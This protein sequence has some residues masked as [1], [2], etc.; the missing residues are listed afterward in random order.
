MI[1]ERMFQIGSSSFISVVPAMMSGYT[2][3]PLNPYAS[4]ITYATSLTILMIAPVGIFIF[5]AS[6]GWS[7]RLTGLW[8]STSLTLGLSGVAGMIMTGLAGISPS[9]GNYLLLLLQWIEFLVQPFCFVAAVIVILATEKFRRSIRYIIT[10]EGVWIRGGLLS[11]QEHMVPY[12]QIG[13]IVFEQDFLG[14]MFNY[15]TLIP[16]SMTRWGQEISFRGIGATGQKDNFG[17]GIGYA[18]GREEGSRYPLDCLY[19]I[20]DPKKAQ[21][22]LTELI[23]RHD[24]REDE[25]VSY[26]KKIYETDVAKTTPRGSGIREPESTVVPGRS[27]PDDAGNEPFAGTAAAGKMPEYPEGKVIRVHDDVIP[28]TTMSPA[29]GNVR[30]IPPLAKTETHPSLGIPP[31]ESVLDQIKKLG[32]LK[33][34]GIITEEEFTAKKTELLKRL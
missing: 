33:T 31:A 7:M 5:F 27:T 20:R 13:R 32:E 19:G 15:G 26:L 21:A 1:L 4:P 24:K 30:E 23:C 34:S 2:T 22:I 25:Q 8:I 6:V 9:S 28:T 3:G 16:Q 17:A 18:K 11:V 29:S 12:D 10:K 14:T